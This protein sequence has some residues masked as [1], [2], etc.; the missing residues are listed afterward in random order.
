MHSELFKNLRK[1]LDHRIGEDGVAALVTEFSQAQLLLLTVSGAGVP[2]DKVAF[3]TV[4]ESKEDS[5]LVACM[6]QAT[7]SS[8]FSDTAIEPWEITGEGIIAMAQKK[9]FDLSIVEGK[10][11]LTL[12][13]EH[14]QVFLQVLLINDG[15]GRDDSGHPAPVSVKQYYPEAFAKWLFDFCRHQPDI[16]K[17]WLGFVSLGG[18]ATPDI[19]IYLGHGTPS[20]RYEQIREQSHLLPPNQTL[21]CDHELLQKYTESKPFY[22][23]ATDRSWWGRLRRR[24]NPRPVTYISME[25]TDG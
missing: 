20:R 5:H 4:G 3:L 12:A 2:E 11:T 1:L 14:L 25:T 15:E 10:D 23:R 13:H 16:S 24:F 8:Q 9:A 7:M 6:D 18:K 19:G 22:D 17:A 21:Y